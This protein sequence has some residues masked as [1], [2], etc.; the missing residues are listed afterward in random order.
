MT[1]NFFPLLNHSSVHGLYTKNIQFLCKI[2]LEYA[3]YFSPRIMS[4]ALQAGW[5]GIF[6][7]WFFFCLIW[8]EFSLSNI[9]LIQYMDL[10][11]WQHH[12][13]FFPCFHESEHPTE[14]Y[15]AIYIGILI[16][17]SSQSSLWD[18]LQIIK[19]CSTTLNK[20]LS[21]K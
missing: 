1:P 2:Q 12:Y 3:L 14:N 7:M 17:T 8:E 19:L 20:C 16:A 6:S 18:R 11:I 13:L 9:S 5:L 10:W 15:K 4:N 21:I